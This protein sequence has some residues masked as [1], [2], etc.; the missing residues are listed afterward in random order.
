LNIHISQSQLIKNHGLQIGITSANQEFSGSPFPLADLDL[1]RRIGFVGGVYVEWLNVSYISIIT[2]I[3]YVQKG[4][5][6]ESIVT[7][8]DSPEPLG[9]KT[10]YSRLDYISLPILMKTSTQIKTV[11]PYI[12]GGLRYD[13][14]LSYE[15]EFMSAVFDNFRRNILGGSIGIGI[16]TNLTRLLNASLEFRYNLDF[17]NSMN[18]YNKEA[19]NN[20]FDIRVGFPF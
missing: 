10:D 15:S 9:T 13:Y 4:L 8:E 12:L 5:G 20:S 11:T 2:Q 3:E 7:G 6:V 1:K 19:K 18:L 16:E 17:T 14:L